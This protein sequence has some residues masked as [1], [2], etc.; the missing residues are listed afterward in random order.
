MNNGN[1][2]HRLSRLEVL[3]TA[4]LISVIVLFVFLV[5][6]FRQQRSEQASC[7]GDSSTGTDARPAEFGSENDEYHRGE[8]GT[9]AAL[10]SSEFSEKSRAIALPVTGDATNV[11]GVMLS[12]NSVD[13][14]AG[15]PSTNPAAVKLTEGEKRPPATAG[16][17]QAELQRIASMP[18]GPDTEKQLQ[19]ALAQWAAT[20]PAS[21]LAYAMNLESRRAG[22]AAV[23]NILD[24]WSQRDP[25][26]A[27]EWFKQHLASNPQMVSDALTNIFGKMAAADPDM[28]LCNVWQ[29]P[30]QG[31]R[32]RALR[33]IVNQ[34]IASGKQDQIMQYFNTLNDTSAQSMLATILVDQ[35]AT[36][37]P[38]ETA[39]WI[40]TLTD[41]A[42]RYRATLTLISKKSAP[43]G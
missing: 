17:I 19:T 20:D 6:Q 13:E 11:A 5:N 16:D 34:M 40:A 24:Q 36:Y 29:L 37:Y 30:Q 12:G 1:S 41:P 42:V 14:V 8:T 39:N 2:R 10:E 26:A 27:Y 43:F 35:W 22:A 21:A 23:S 33:T 38:K 31:M 32:N 18:W 15:R 28:A 25:S 9:I 7:A 3:L 4:V